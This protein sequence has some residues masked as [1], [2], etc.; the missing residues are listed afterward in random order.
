MQLEEVNSRD[1]ERTRGDEV[2]QMLAF[3]KRRGVD[4]PDVDFMLAAMA[5][6]IPSMDAALGAGGNINVTDTELLRKYADLLR[7]FPDV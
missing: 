1:G 2:A 3:L 7:G 6:D 4:D 5:G